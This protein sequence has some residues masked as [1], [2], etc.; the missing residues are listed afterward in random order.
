MNEKLS[1]WEVIGGLSATGVI[2]GLG[3]LLASKEEL[4]ARIIWGRAMSSLGLSLAAGT[5][6]IQF[7][8]IPPLAL[9]GAG[10]TLSSLGTSFLERF[11]Q[12]KLGID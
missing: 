8:E 2:I 6:L 11:L 5:I 12:R 9:I 10:A 1:T 7:P 3:Q 4:T